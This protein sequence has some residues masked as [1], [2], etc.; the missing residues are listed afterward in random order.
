MQVRGKF[1]L[2]DAADPLHQEGTAV[3]AVDGRHIVHPVG[4]GGDGRQLKIDEIHVVRQQ[5]IGRLQALHV[6]FFDP[7]LLADERRPGKQRHESRD[8]HGLPDGQLR[9]IVIFGIFVVDIHGNNL[10]SAFFL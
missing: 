3:V 9:G 6:D 4:E 2:A 1:P 7:I 8:D 10:I 5:H